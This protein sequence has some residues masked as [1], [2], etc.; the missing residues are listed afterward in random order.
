MER[1]GGGATSSTTGVRSPAAEPLLVCAW[2]GV[3]GQLPAMPSQENSDHL[4]AVGGHGVRGRSKGLCLCSS[5]TTPAALCHS[6]RGCVSGSFE[7]RLP[8]P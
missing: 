5:L 4:V 7:N 2:S 1:L 8:P 3:L 6:W